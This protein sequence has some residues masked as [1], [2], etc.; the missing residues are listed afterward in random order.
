MSSIRRRKASEARGQLR[1]RAAS[2][3]AGVGGQTLSAFLQRGPAVDASP[4]AL[5]ATAANARR[6]QIAPRCHS[7][8]S[9]SLRRTSRADRARIGEVLL[10]RGCE[11]AATD[12][13]PR[14]EHRRRE[15]AK[16]PL[17]DVDFPGPSFV[18]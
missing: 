14:G 1:R 6:R 15:A 17:V 9:V 5:R 16:A 4:V 11:P 18:P 12:L 8:H 7:T 3:N 2:G 13:S 10:R